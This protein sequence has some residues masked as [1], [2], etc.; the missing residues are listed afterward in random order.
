MIKRFSNREKYIEGVEKEL[1]PKDPIV[2]IRLAQIEAWKEKFIRELRP[3]GS[4]KRKGFQR[5][6]MS[7]EFADVP[8]PFNFKQGKGKEASCTIDA[9]HAGQEYPKDIQMRMRGASSF[10]FNRPE[11]TD[12][13]GDRYTDIIVEKIGQTTNCNALIVET[14]RLAVD[15]NRYPKEWSFRARD[16]YNFN[17]PE[18]SR[19]KA[20]QFIL[21]YQDKMKGLIRVSESKRHLHLAIHGMV[22]RELIDGKPL[23]VVIGTLGGRICDSDIEAWA[24]TS[25][26][27]KLSKELG[28][29]ANIC[30]TTLNKPIKEGRPRRHP[31]LEK[32]IKNQRLE[33]KDL[34]GKEKRDHRLMR[35]VGSMPQIVHRLAYP[36]V[37]TV[38]FEL[39][40][41]LR[42]NHQKEISKVLAEMVKEFGEKFGFKEK[43]PEVKKTRP[44]ILEVKEAPSESISRLTKELEPETL[45]S[46]IKEARIRALTSRMIGIDKDTKERFSLRD[47]QR[48]IV[49]IKDTKIATDS[50]VYKGTPDKLRLPNILRKHL[51]L[52][53]KDIGKR[54]NVERGQ[55]RWVPKIIIDWQKEGESSIA[56]GNLKTIKELKQD[57]IAREKERM[58][59]SL[60][61]R[62]IGLPE[63]VRDKLGVRSKES[64]LIENKI[65]GKEAVGVVFEGEK[66]FI[67]LTKRLRS[68][69]GLEDELIGSQLKIYLIEE[70]G[71]KRIIIDKK[72]R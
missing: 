63:E 16:T 33:Y 5:E 18:D 59:R 68:E 21:E 64:I 72:E 36:Y 50:I 14:S 60:A 34:E 62:M 43:K 53:D 23:D 56:Q 4:V 26:K 8:Q 48:V 52:E 42:K 28:R 12:L 25:L 51:E 17:A 19:R 57:L 32:E 10:N 66:K 47:G 70:D 54:C 20:E 35:L 6:K 15:F 49:E 30:L 44:E 71:K 40:A 61:R 67:Q 2:D 45:P 3:E 29:E 46:L 13:K 58:A 11:K 69:I 38:Q 31:V 37:N 65:T 1:V 9:V 27:K 55:I 22:Q 41:D 24:Y 7:G 39:S